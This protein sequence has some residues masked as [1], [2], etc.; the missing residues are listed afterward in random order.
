MTK[1]AVI[2]PAAG[3]GDR[4]GGKQNKVFAKLDGRPIFL[5]TVELFINR[6]DI[7]QT[8]L[9]VAPA[10]MEEM[11]K[12]YGAN[13]GFMGVTLVEG[14]AHRWETVSNGLKKLSEDAQFVAIHDAVRPCASSSLID[15]VIAEATKSGAAI[16]A[17]AVA[18][19]LKRVSAQNVVDETVSREGLYEVQTP[20]VF[21]RDL[22]EKAYT[23]LGY[24]AKE[25]TDDA[26]AVELSGGTVTVVPGESTNLK[27]THKDDL[28]LANA[29]LK[30]RPAKAVPRL[31]AFEEAKW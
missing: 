24:K 13:L 19:T 10:D 30:A 9:S 18:A 20:Q 1:V 2:I 3:R 26:Q 6:D 5:R 14:G 12:R 25:L 28:A 31:G 16:P 11:K 17:V 15:A 29:I 27:I 7:C 23:A 4:F 22:I 8:I 21:R